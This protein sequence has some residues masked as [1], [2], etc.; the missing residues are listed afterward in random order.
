MKNLPFRIAIVGVGPKGLY[1]FERILAQLKAN[2]V[3]EPVEIHLFNK[4]R[5]MGSGDVYRSDQPK[6]LLMNFSNAH[7]N[8]WSGE[9]PP[10]VIK[11]P[12]RFSEDRARKLQTT[13]EKIDRLYAARAIVGAYLENGFSRL[14]QNLPENVLVHQH[15]AEVR[16]I[17]R[18]GQSYKISF[19]KHKKIGVISGFQQILITTGHQRHKIPTNTNYNLI[20]FVYPVEKT[21]K[22]V[23]EKQTVVV[24]GMGLTCI[25]ALL[26][27]TE[28][29]GGAFD[30]NTDGT[31]TYFASGREPKHIFPFSKSGLLMLPKYDFN[32]EKEKPTLYVENSKLYANEKLSFK[33]DI[34]PLVIQDMEYAYY[35]TL[36]THEREV[37]TY[38]ADYKEIKIQIE[39]F[40]NNYPGYP[41]FSLEKLLNPG[42]NPNKSTHENTIEYIA[43]FITEN[44]RH[45]VHEAK[46]RAAAVWRKISP[47]FNEIYSF[48]GLNPISHQ[49]FDTYYFG[50]LNRVAYGP[51]PQNLK[52]IIALAQ[53]GIVDFQFAANPHIEPCGSGIAL[54]NRNSISYGDVLIDAR[55]PKN[56]LKKEASGLFRSLCENGLAKPY[57]NADKYNLY[58]PGALEI[59]RKGALINPQ[60]KPENIS[61]YGTPTEGIVHDNDTLSRTRNNF[62]RYWAH[63]VIQQLI[64]RKNE[65]KNQSSKPI[66]CNQ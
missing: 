12:L 56:S 38:H 52:K 42:L 30:K 45:I 59:N 10:P 48:G 36:F 1:G 15:I 37:L 28:G 5:Y 60:G 33:N 31:Y 66:A 49:E 26:A 65:T 18:V 7:I 20:P 17:D 6:Y 61:L 44:N 32:P 22:R 9:S 63:S 51:P 27:L 34:L 24:K 2:P 54:S 14:C 21:L 64:T 11:N 3:H 41:R 58:E 29:R 46:L 35:N 16:S 47:V 62:S 19:E 50:K 13:T 40:H 23:T 4:T 55:I 53:A 57:K 43:A 8:M 39:A 25:D